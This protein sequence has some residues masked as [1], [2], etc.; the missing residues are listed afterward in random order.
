MQQLRDLEHTLLNDF[1]E[2]LL[3]VAHEIGVGEDVHEAITEPEVKIEDIEDRFQVNEI[4][5]R[6]GNR[7]GPADLCAE[8]IESDGVV[9]TVLPRVLQEH[10][11]HERHFPVDWSTAEDVTGS[12]R[13]WNVL[14][15][16]REEFEVIGVAHE[17]KI[18]INGAQRYENVL[19]KKKNFSSSVLNK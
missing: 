2:F 9:A 19:K 4:E 18:I 11:T 13:Q 6:F 14:N 7:E 16:L 17:V 12:K 1:V 8:P 15:H 3:N 10:R 5:N